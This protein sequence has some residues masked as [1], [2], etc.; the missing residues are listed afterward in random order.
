MKCYGKKIMVFFNL[1]LGLVMFLC[2]V[3]LGVGGALL[4][5]HFRRPESI[6]AS[7][8]PVCLPLM[9]GSAATL[10][11]AYIYHL[12]AAGFGSAVNALEVM[13]ENLAQYTVKADSSLD[14]IS[15]SLPV[16]QEKLENCQQEIAAC[17]ENEQLMAEF[18]RELNQCKEILSSLTARR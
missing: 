4:Y 2:V 7:Y 12:L 15:A 3:G 8:Y 16:L 13:R 10:V 1:L 11:F 17:R 6:Y 5:F 18:Q 14:K 9:C